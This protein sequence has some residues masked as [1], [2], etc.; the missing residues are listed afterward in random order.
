MDIASALGLL[1][2]RALMGSDRNV[3]RELW[4]RM[5]TLPGGKQLF[6]RAIGFAA[7]YTATIRCKVEILREGYAEVRMLDRPDLRNHLSCVHAVALVNL[8]EVT[9]NV[10]LAYSLPDDGR[11]IVAGLDIEYLKKARG[12]IRATSDCPIPTSSERKEYRVPVSMWNGAGE[13]VARATLRTLVG[14]KKG[15]S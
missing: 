9:G 13:E 3:V 11:F 7:P 5:S 6:S 4:D 14:P 15:T 8:A 12:T 1:S 10:A 2:P